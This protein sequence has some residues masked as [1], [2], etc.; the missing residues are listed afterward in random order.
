[1]VLRGD[2]SRM[3]TVFKFY[4]QVWMWFS[5]AA[6]VAGA[7]LM[8]VVLRWRP[9]LRGAWL[10]ALIALV[11]MAALYPA[12]A[13]QA[14]I[15]DRMASEAPHTLDGMEF[16][17]YAQ[18]FENG[19]TFSLAPDYNALRWLQFNVAGQPVVLE[20]NIPEYRWGSRVS[21]YTGLPSIVGWNW[22]QRQQ[23]SLISGEVVFGRVQDVT[24]AYNTTS[25]E[26][27]LRIIDRYNVEY[28]IVGDLERAYYDANGLAKF[29]TMAG[30]GLLEVV[31]SR[32]GTTI[33]RVVD[34]AL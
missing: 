33:Y 9:T 17:R 32:D 30:Q 6:G 34:D 31:Y 24:D 16:M 27:A 23:R 18:R 14:K 4:L 25:V 29:E 26:E 10:V 22:H 8:P 3:N 12:L 1:V 2:V 5:V 28:I 19:Q 21:I 11:G 13:A 7:W 20:A 15:D